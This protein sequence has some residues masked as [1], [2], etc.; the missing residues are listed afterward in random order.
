MHKS[1]FKHQMQ[2]R[3]DDALEKQRVIDA[4]WREVCRLVT[5][6]E[7]GRCRVYGTRTDPFA[8]GRAHHGHHHH[9]MPRS[10]GG[11]DTTANLVLISAKAHDEIHVKKTLVVEGDADTGLTISTRDAEGNW[12]VWRQE[13]G[14]RQYARD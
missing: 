13:T 4:N 8:V 6:R 10:R 5:Q 12:V 14:V 2:T 3:L 7:E 1:Y 9:I 11:A